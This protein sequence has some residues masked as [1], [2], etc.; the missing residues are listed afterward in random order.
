MHVESRQGQISESEIISRPTN[1]KRNLN[2]ATSQGLTG[3]TF[4]QNLSPQWTT[5]AMNVYIDDDQN[6]HPN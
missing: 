1:Q 5:F 3:V 4:T 6:D 2:P